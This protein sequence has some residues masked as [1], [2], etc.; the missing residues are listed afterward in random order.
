MVETKGHRKNDC[1]NDRNIENPELNMSRNEAVNGTN[2]NRL[3]CTPAKRPAQEKIKT[4]P[5][6]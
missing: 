4:L 2:N 6:H 5:E 1:T 3:K